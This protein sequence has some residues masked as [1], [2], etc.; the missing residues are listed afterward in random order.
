MNQS[1]YHFVLTFRGGP[2]GDSKTV[3]AEA[4]FHDHSFPKIDE[5]FE[6]LSRYI[7]EKGDFE[8]P[9]SVFDELWQNYEEMK[10]LG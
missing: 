7:E 8:M 2:K 6:P 4:M 3:F 1:F 5:T 10:R 9:A